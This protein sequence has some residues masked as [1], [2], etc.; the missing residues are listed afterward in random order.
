MT[1][2]ELKTIYANDEPDDLANLYLEINKQVEKSKRHRTFL[3]FG[4]F[5]AAYFLLLCI[6]FKPDS[7][8]DIAAFLFFSIF[9]SFF[10]VAIHLT[11][12]QWFISNQQEDNN[13]RQFIDKR[14]HFL[15]ERVQHMTRT[16]MAEKIATRIWF[17]C[18]SLLFMHHDNPAAIAVVWTAILY[19]LR[20]RLDDLGIF[21]SV[22]RAFAD[23][24]PLIYE[25][26]FD[27]GPDFEFRPD[28]IKPIFYSPND[29]LQDFVDSNCDL[30]Q[31][32]ERV[33][34]F[35]LTQKLSGNEIDRE[36]YDM[37]TSYGNGV[38]PEEYKFIM[39]LDFDPFFEV[40]TKANNYVKYFQNQRGTKPPMPFWTL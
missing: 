9:L 3:L 37:I 15:A 4:G 2:E 12:F 29:F 26:I 17:Y 36:D 7:F 31:Q 10:H 40:I 21:V 25:G 38:D 19:S 14:L 6:G 20:D 8:G 24:A 16:E 11:V 28:M 30:T 34:F 35:L 13:R 23:T 22:K 18:R 5:F 1:D 39:S 32:N 33:A 27:F